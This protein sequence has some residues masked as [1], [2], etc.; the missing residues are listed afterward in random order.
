MTVSIRKCVGQ[1]FKNNS[2]LELFAIVIPA[3]L[4]LPKNN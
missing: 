3:L 1:L 2:S 4:C